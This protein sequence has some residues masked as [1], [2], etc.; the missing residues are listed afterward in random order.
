MVCAST[1]W[2]AGK[3]QENVGMSEVGFGNQTFREMWAKE[4]NMDAKDPHTLSLPDRGTLLTN[5]DQELHDS[6][7]GSGPPE[8]QKRA[9]F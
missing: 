7:E 9:H 2:R 4:I 6:K 5:T 3:T 8:C 1:L